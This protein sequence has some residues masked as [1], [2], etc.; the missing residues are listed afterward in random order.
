MLARSFGIPLRIERAGF[1]KCA[2]E[3]D[4]LHHL[5][6]WAGR[7]LG[8]AEAVEHFAGLEPAEGF[9]RLLRDVGEDGVGAAER[10]DGDPATS[11]GL[12]LTGL[13]GD[14]LPRLGDRLPCVRLEL[15]SNG[16]YLH[17]NLQ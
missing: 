2:D 3:R 1:A 6:Q 4:E 11:E 14:T 7:R 10:D 17:G 12:F 5:D 8:H 9:D 15:V 16:L 13:K